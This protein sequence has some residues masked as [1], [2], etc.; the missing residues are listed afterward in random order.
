[1]KLSKVLSPLRQ[2]PFARYIAGETVS[3]VGTWMQ[4]FAQ[5]WVL[6]ALTQKATVLGAINFASGIPMLLLTMLGG[7][8]ADRHDKRRILFCVLGAQIACALAL[9]WLIASKGIAI[10]HILVAAIVLGIASAFE[11][12]AVSALVPELVRRDQIGNAIALDRSLFHLTRLIGPA[13]SGALIGWYGAA[14]A[15]YVNALSFLPLAAALLSIAPRVAGSADEEAKR[16]GGIR[17]GI[18]YVRG[19]APTR[20]MIV[21]MS[22][23]TFFVSPFLL[24]LMPLY[25]RV[26]LGLPAEKM[27]VLMAISGIGSFT[28]ALGLLSVPHGHRATALKVAAGLIALGL[29]GLAASASLRLACFAIV[30]LALGLSATFGISNIIIQER[31]PDHLRGRV[32]AV[33]GLSFFGLVPFSGLLVAG[34]VDWIGMRHAMACAAILFAASAA[35]LLAGIRRLASAPFPSEARQAPSAIPPLADAK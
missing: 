6:T 34:T 19:D 26:T 7:S 22:L 10:W 15:Y 8:L 31:A 29:G 4:F 9:G 24:V 12:P 14:S 30:C 11:V 21:L 35:V 5:G 1:M 3:M 20:S 13:V 32:S 18:A 2:G 23:T 25:S 28:G 17:D 27:G 16:S 33:A